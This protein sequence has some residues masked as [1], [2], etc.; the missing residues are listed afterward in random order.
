MTKPDE[1]EL[2]DFLSR[3]KLRE[4]V[5]DQL[6]TEFT[7]LTQATDADQLRRAQGRAGLLTSIRVLLDKAPD[8]V[9]R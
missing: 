1:L 9:K 7:V 4:W 3:T 6:K 2:F 8:A 5:E